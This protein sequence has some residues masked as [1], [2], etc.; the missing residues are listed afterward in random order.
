MS[1]ALRTK[2]AYN[3]L[4]LWEKQCLQMLSEG[5]IIDRRVWEAL[6]DRGIANLPNDSNWLTTYGNELL[7][8]SREPNARLPQ[9]RTGKL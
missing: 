5:V 4:L 3:E 9:T 8:Q 6:Y 1:E 2:R 7:E